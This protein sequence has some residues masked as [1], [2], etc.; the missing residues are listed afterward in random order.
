MENKVILV[1]LID[2]GF[3]IETSEEEVP[4]E[5]IG[6]LSKY[7]LSDYLLTEDEDRALASVRSNGEV[8][9]FV[10]TSRGRLLY[11][12]AFKG[13]TKLPFQANQNLKWK[14]EATY[15][16]PTKEQYKAVKDNY[17]FMPGI[18]SPVYNGYHILGTW[19]EKVK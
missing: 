4:F 9:I 5:F 12:T 17:C 2:N 18:G 3:W 16:F 13:T 11:E 7:L 1:K 15:G 6:T 10:I 14:E 19:L 8:A